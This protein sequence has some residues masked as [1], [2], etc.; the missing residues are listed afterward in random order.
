MSFIR[1][2]WPPL[3]LSLGIFYLN[4][5][6]LIEK[7]LFTRRFLPFVAINL[8]LL[9]FYIYTTDLMWEWMVANFPMD[10]KRF[11]NKGG[12]LAL[13]T[14]YRS[15]YSLFLNVGGSIA[16]KVTGTWFR[17]EDQRKFLENERLKS[18][19]SN[20]RYQLQPHFFFNTLNN[21]YALVDIS[22]VRA[23][24]ALHGLSKLMRYLLYETPGETAS[25]AREI[26]FLQSYIRLM[27]MRLP[28]HVELTYTFPQVPGDMQLPPLLFVSLVENA[29]KHGV[30]GRQPSR[31]RFDMKLEDK[32]LRFTTENTLFPRNEEDLSESGIGL[33]NLKKRLKLLYPGK[34][35][36]SA[37]ATGDLF[38][39]E[40]EIEL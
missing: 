39:C 24:E 26:E 6:Y 11:K 36:F 8:S 13:S 16:I 35:R 38:R 34:Y 21:I 9:I 37:G 27:Q 18:E 32:H 17:S 25:F 15:L 20:L 33:E 3:V 29:F 7:F 14:M 1:R 19:L 12:N 40:L 28:E 2:T 23:K 30:S 5:F 10:G 22:P 4:Y 31:I